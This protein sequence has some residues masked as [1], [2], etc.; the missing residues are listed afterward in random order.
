VAFRRLASCSRI[1]GCMHVR[2]I[3]A[4]YVCT[5][6]HTCMYVDGYKTEN[7]CELKK[8]MCIGTRGFVV[9]ADTGGMHA[10]EKR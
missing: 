5:H 8:I 2:A 10:N 9:K 7:K 3:G 6:R 1:D 4:N